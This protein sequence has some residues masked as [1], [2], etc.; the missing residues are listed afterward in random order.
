MP[1]VYENR[2]GTSSFF[3]QLLISAESLRRPI[4]PQ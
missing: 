4:H 1:E 2:R 3:Q